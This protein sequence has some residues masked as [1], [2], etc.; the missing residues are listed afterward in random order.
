MM[1]LVVV[2]GGPETGSGPVADDL[3]KF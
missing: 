2:M 1:G 3:L